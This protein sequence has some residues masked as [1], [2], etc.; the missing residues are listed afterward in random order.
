MRNLQHSYAVNVKIGK[1][2]AQNKLKTTELDDKVGFRRGTI[3]RIINKQRLVRT[4]ELMPICRALG[5]SA[6]A[7]MDGRAAGMFTDR[8]LLYAYHYME[9]EERHIIDAVV[10]RY[11][12][13]KMMGRV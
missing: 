12:R 5:V 13:K 8:E 7:L 11:L 9:E 3:R 10:K 2:V 6:E 1:I 4:D